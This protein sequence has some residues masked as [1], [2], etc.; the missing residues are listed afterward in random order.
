M[1]S[2]IESWKHI[3]P[4][5]S[6]ETLQKDC[7]IV[8]NSR[9]I[10]AEENY[11]T[12]STYFIKADETPNSTLER[13]AKAI[14]E[15]HTKGKTFDINNSGAE[16]WS[17]VI[18]PEDD[19]GI[20][21]DRDYDLEEEQGL[22]VHPHMGTVTYLSNRGAPTIVMNKVGS[23]KA[24]TDI[25]GNI[26]EMAVCQ[27]HSGNHIRFNGDLL[28]AAPAEIVQTLIEDVDEDE[29]EGDSAGDDDDEDEDLEKL[30]KNLHKKRI[31]F[32]VNI[33][34]DHIPSQASRYEQKANIHPQLSNEPSH[35]FVQFESKLQI[36]NTH[37]DHNIEMKDHNTIKRVI[38]LQFNNHDVIYDVKIPLPSIDLM[39]QELNEKHLLFLTY[40]NEDHQIQLLFSEVQL[41]DMENEEEGDEGDGEGEGEEEEGAAEEDD[42][43]EGNEDDEEEESEEDNDEE[44]EKEHQKKKARR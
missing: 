5:D 21:W 31:S 18:H 23:K 35:S 26:S 7:A 14:F 15:H 36:H 6:L 29:N 10:N 38:T 30:L 41:S 28:H 9:A 17:Q 42:S 44:Y 20:H 13:L 3:L 27:C 37:G 32:L 43:F 12:G 16:W 11:S 25:V 8:F 40:P 19:I 33:W 1:T 4:K 34:L 39:K 22:H 2:W 24:E